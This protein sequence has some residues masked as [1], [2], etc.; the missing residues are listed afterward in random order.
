MSMTADF[1]HLQST[2]HK[3]S[4]SRV[5][6]GF[7]VFPLTSITLLLFGLNLSLAVVL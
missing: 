5:F 4:F 1:Y 6:L 3:G 2:A 7:A